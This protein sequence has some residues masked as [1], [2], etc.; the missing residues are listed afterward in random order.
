NPERRTWFSAFEALLV[1]LNMLVWRPRAI[2]SSPA[3]PAPKPGGR[4]FWLVTDFRAINSRTENCP[5]PMPNAEA[6]TIALSQQATLSKWI[7]SRATGNPLSQGGQ[8]IY[9]MV[10]EGLFS[11]TRVPQGVLNVT[12]HFHAQMTAVSKGLLN[13]ICLLWVDDVVIWGADAEDLVSILDDVLG[14]L[15]EY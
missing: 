8:D 2:W 4:G 9:T 6:M 10:T 15:G 5:F 14:G 12:S 3:I 13:K 7:C 11:P 1:F